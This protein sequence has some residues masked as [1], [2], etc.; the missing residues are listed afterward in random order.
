MG[1]GASLLSNESLKDLTDEE[2]CTL[3]GKMRTK[4]D[5]LSPSDTLMSSKYTGPTPH[6]FHL[7]T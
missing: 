3:L 7:T 1:G 5:E 4:Y 2:K 6:N